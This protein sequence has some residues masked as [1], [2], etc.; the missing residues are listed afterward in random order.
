VIAASLALVA[1]LGTASHAD[2]LAHLFGFLVGGALGAIGALARRR[3]VPGWGQ[4]GL[5]VTAGGAV[6]LAWRLAA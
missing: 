1:L 5:V 3:P 2:V 6:A 4:A